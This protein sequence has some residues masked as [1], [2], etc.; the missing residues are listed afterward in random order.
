MKNVTLIRT[1]RTG[2]YNKCTKLYRKIWQR[3]QWD[4]QSYQHIHIHRW[5][6]HFDFYLVSLHSPECVAVKNP[7][8]TSVPQPMPLPDNEVLADINP[9]HNPNELKKFNI[10]RNQLLIDEVEL[11]SG[12]FGCVK[13]GVLTT[14]K[15]GN[16]RL[17]IY[18]MCIV[19]AFYHNSVA[20]WYLLLNVP[21]ARLTL[22][23]KCWR[24]IMRSSWRRRWWGRQR[25]CTN[26][27][28]P[29]SFACWACAMLRT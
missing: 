8:D 13:K 18:C 28:T 3:I 27:T 16:T 22:P 26:W 9:Y 11:G 10:Q 19:F 6:L 23:S 4:A 5:D 2:C 21:E 1:L 20:S 17:Y 7:D 25:S 29:T 14:D 15:W 12:N 24:T